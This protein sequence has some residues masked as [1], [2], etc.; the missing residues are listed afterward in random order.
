MVMPQPICSVASALQFA[1]LAALYRDARTGGDFFEFVPAGNGRL[2]LVLLDIAGKRDET[3][4]IAASVQRSLRSAVPVMFNT[5]DKN[6]ADAI[7]ELTHQL[8]SGILEAA[9][10][11]RC[12]AGFI[13]CYSEEFG[14]LTYVNAGHVP[15]LLRHG[16]EISVLES[17]GVPLGLFSH[18][19]YDAQVRVVPEGA[20]LLL[21]SRGVLEVKAG[22]E[23][24]GL[25][26]LKSSLL[27]ANI[28]GSANE[29]CTQILRGLSVFMERGMRRGIFG[30]INSSANGDRDSLAQ[31]DL[32]TV[33][34]IRSR[35]KAGAAAAR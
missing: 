11:V 33:A 4:N 34:L 10:G 9:G 25:D 2:V 13:G 21:A 5:L 30:F 28:N 23:E 32:T 14:V 16:E 8:N 3:M 17:S 22:S 12:T 15:A 7:S 35:V 19:T 31:N 26:R 18:I 20:A 27:D 24:Y 6:E 1:D 29:L